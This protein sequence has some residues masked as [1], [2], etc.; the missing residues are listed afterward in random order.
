MGLP[1]HRKVFVRKKIITVS[2]TII[3]ASIG[4]TIGHSSPAL[5]D[6]PFEKPPVIDAEDLLPAKFLKGKR[7]EVER[8]VPT[9]GFLGRFTLRT[10]YGTME[11]RGRDLL[12]IRVGEIRSIKALHKK[13]K[14][15]VFASA[16]KDAALRPINAVKQVIKNPEETLDGIPAGVERFFH[17][18]YRSAKKTTMNAVDAVSDYME[19]KPDQAE[20]AEEE[21][22]AEEQAAENVEMAEKVVNKAGNVAKD[23]FGYN[24]ARRQLAKQLEIDPYTTNP[25]LNQTLDESAWAAFA[26]GMAFKMAV[27]IP[28]AVSYTTKVSNLVWDLPPPDLEEINRKKL[29]KMGIKGRPVRDFFR[30]NAFSPTLT[31]SLVAALDQ[32]DRVTGREEV[33]ALATDTASEEEARY[34]TGSTRLLAHYHKTV[35]PLI[36]ITIVG[37]IVGWNQEG[38]IIVP[39]DV[40]YIAWTRRIAEFAQHP[41]LQTP[42]RHLWISGKFSPLAKQ[43]LRSLGWTVREEIRAAD[44]PE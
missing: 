16:A 28:D 41:N 12:Q 9:N 18:A 15:K 32:L 4:F 7:Y 5:A 19:E 42:E 20:P 3:L 27:P 35:S 44:R 40:D 33:I 8:K 25:I 17:N 29:K 10:D 22:T 6:A 21:K 13:G 38:N 14:V 34:L 37:T 36:G 31:T 1:L 30:N 24:K 43:E 23:Y 2:F 11:V 26:G 39:S